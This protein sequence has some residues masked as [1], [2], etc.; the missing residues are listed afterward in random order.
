M[1][2]SA[3][4]ASNGAN[5]FLDRYRSNLNTPRAPPPLVIRQR[6]PTPPTPPPLII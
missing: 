4:Q 1:A 2:A 5:S 6:P 3:G